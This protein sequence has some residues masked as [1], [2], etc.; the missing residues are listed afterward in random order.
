MRMSRE[1]NYALRAALA[2]WMCVEDAQESIVAHISWIA[3]STVSRFQ[4]AA[5]VS[6]N[7]PLYICNKGFIMLLIT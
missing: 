5:A 3:V 4:D 2:P 6:E 1:G 7:K